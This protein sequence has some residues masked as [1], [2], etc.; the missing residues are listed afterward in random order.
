MK[1][2]VCQTSA[3]PGG[4]IKIL[5]EEGEMEKENPLNPQ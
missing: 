1:I 3:K 2:R 4:S 5:F